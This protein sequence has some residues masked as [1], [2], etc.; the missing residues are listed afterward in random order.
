MKIYFAELNLVLELNLIRIVN[1][2]VRFEV[3]CRKMQKQILISESEKTLNNGIY[4]EYEKAYLR[5]YIFEY[6]FF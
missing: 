6:F 2:N 1:V 4:F 5:I 3:S